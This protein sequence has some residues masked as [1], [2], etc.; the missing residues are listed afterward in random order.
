VLIKK[1]RVR[2]A[3]HI[4]DLGAFLVEDFVAVARNSAVNHFQA[5]QRFRGPL[6][7]GLF[8][9][10][11]ANKLRLLQLA[12]AVESGLPHIDGIGDFVPVERQLG[13][14]AQR[15]A[16]A[17]SARKRAELATRL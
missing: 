17:E 7:L 13:F 2:A 16:R 6:S 15:V 14:E 8:E 3:S 5:N 11:L 4:T 12:E 1:W 9:S 10:V